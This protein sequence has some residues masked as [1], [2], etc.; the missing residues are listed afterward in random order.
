MVNSNG[1]TTW[2]Y[3]L[4][5]GTE[6]ESDN[7]P[8]PAGW[9]VPT[10]AEI[11]TLFNTDKVS[12]YQSYNGVNGWIFID[13]TTD[14]KLFLPVAGYRSIR[15]GSL[16]QADTTSYYWGS[17]TYQ[18]DT[19]CCAWSLSLYSIGATVSDINRMYG[20]LVRCVRE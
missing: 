7:D 17:S 20:F 2:D 1:G 12:K 10:L 13:K 16:R 5:S 3:S 18:Y 6:W 19:G 4:P 8:S 11:Q 9:R 14:K 15:D